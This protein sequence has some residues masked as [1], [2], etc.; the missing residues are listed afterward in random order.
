[1][2]NKDIIEAFSIVAKE[3]N[4]DRTNLSTI[5]EDLFMTMIYKKYGEERENFSV[6]VNMEKGEIEIYQEKVV[7][8]DVVDP[9]CE[10][11]LENALKVEPDLEIDD[12]FIDILSPEDFGR[13][14]INTAKQHLAQRI[15]D[16]ERESIFDDFNKK[17]GEIV[18]GSVHQIQRDRIFVNLDQAELLLPKVE[19]LPNDRY[20]RGESVRG[21][22]KSVEFTSKGPEIMLSRSDNM[23]L[24]RLFEMEIPEIE[25]GII[26][27]KA[28][29]RSA[30]DRSKIV[31]YSS[32]QR[33]DAVGACVG[34]RGS[35]IQSVVRELNGEKIDIINWS[36][37]PEIFISRALA[38]A[39]PI[40]LYID[41][42][43]PYVV[44]VFE[45]EELPIAIGRN[46]QNIK[47][48]SDV[49]GY[50]IDAVKKTDYEG[51]TTE[52][53][54]LDELSG[55]AATQLEL[56]SKN[57]IHTGDDF[58]DADKA[59]LLELKGFGEK[60]ISKISAIIEEKLSSMEVEEPDAIVEAAE[61]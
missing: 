15:R 12:P 50:T 54:Y 16:I 23:F 24:E 43:R 48:A 17:I 19:Q 35:R 8:Q 53:V 2:I 30:G 33:I 9:V 34:M 27:I 5:I 55:I 45:D 10:I 56:L 46:G 44:A 7:V 40:N 11:S 1:M 38:P 26:E 59:M 6:I 37:Q 18:V 52:V 60:T 22:I 39:K 3:K 28:V 25:D 36:S 58:L 51:T 41:E 29:S 32:D 21:V 57:E 47:L 42:E 61:E 14:L 4:I 31:V 13:R 49:T 20:R